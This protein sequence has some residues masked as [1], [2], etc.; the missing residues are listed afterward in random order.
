MVLENNIQI[1]SVT[2]NRYSRYIPPHIIDTAAVVALR[3]L[4]PDHYRDRRRPNG[5]QANIGRVP[6]THITISAHPGRGSG[7]RTASSRQQ[8][9]HSTRGNPF[10]AGPFAEPRSYCTHAIILCTRGHKIF[11]KTG[12]VIRSRPSGGSAGATVVKAAGVYGDVIIT[13]AQ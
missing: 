3:F 6:N 7:K 4:D 12:H 13:T 2:W 9:K 1:G 8:R 5:V 11:I 10:R